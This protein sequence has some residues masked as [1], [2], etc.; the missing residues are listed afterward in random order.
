MVHAAEYLR[1][2]TAAGYVTIGARSP[3]VAFAGATTKGLCR[4]D[5]CY[6]ASIAALGEKTPPDENGRVLRSGATAGDA[7]H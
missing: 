1:G 2:P 4:Q 3:P 6:P 5:R 7:A